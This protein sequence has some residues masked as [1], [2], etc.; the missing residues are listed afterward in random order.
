[1]RCEYQKSHGRRFALV[2]LATECTMR[3][4]QLGGVGAALAAAALGI[5]VSACS[6]SDPVGATT[7]PS[8]APAVNATMR[9]ST[10]MQTV[11]A[12]SGRLCLAAPVEAVPGFFIGPRIVEVFVTTSQP[13]DLSQLTLQ[14]IDGSH[15]GGPS[16]TFPQ[17]TLNSVLG[18][19]RI[20]TGSRTFSVQ[21][22]FDCA[23]QA[24]TAIDGL[25]TFVDSTGASHTIS[26]SAPFD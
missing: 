13:I 22:H 11:S 18:S 1:M 15:L 14:L 2:R 5:A 21:A 7:A 23:A 6:G 8:V 12:F 20:L 16:I 24:P 25:L 17:A 10:A 3:R 9:A 4:A 26:V 19:T